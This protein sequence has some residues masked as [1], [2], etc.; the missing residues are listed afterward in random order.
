MDLGTG[1]AGWGLAVFLVGLIAAFGFAIYK[2]YVTVTFN[3]GRRQ[4]A[5]PDRLG[6]ATDDE[7]APIPIPTL[8]TLGAPSRPAVMFAG[9]QARLESELGAANFAREFWSTQV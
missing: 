6:R 4:A 9:Q 2:K 5:E 1:A 8:P 3:F 7:T